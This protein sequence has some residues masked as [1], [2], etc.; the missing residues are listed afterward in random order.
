MIA[1]EPR[2]GG[3]D[4]SEAIRDFCGDVDEFWAWCPTVEELAGPPFDLGDEAEQAHRRY[5]DW[6]LQL[7]RRLVSPWP[8]GWPTGLCDLNAAVRSAGI[9]PPPNESAHHPRGDASWNAA[10]FRLL[11]AT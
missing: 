11:Q 2:L 8:D 5:W 7:L 4:L 6:D 10:V 9:T 3:D 1:E